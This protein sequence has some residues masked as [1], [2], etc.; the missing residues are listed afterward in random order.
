[1]EQIPGLQSCKDSSVMEVSVM[2]VS[3]VLMHRYIPAYHH[4][5]YSAINR[6]KGNRLVY[7][8]GWLYVA[9]G[10]GS[11]IS[12]YKPTTTLQPKVL[13]FVWCTLSRDTTYYF[14]KTMDNQP[15]KYST[16]IMF[17]HAVPS[18]AP[19]L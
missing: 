13:S 6:S 14:Q 16:H 15:E 7:F 9:S 12:L 10:N 5:H 8:S 1:M 3:V 19:F 17:T 2:E 4:P 11:V 18:K